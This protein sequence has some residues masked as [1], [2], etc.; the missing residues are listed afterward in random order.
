MG[1][2]YESEVRTTAHRETSTPASLH[3]N[4]RPAVKHSIL[5]LIAFANIVSITFG[6]ADTIPTETKSLQRQVAVPLGSHLPQRFD[7]SVRASDIDPR[8]KE[9]P[10][11]GFVFNDNNGKPRD[12]QHAV[13]DTRVPP[14]GQ[15]VI[16][17]M[18]HNQGLFER[19]A[20]YGLHGIQPHYANGWF[21]KLDAKDRDD[22]VSLGKI[23]LEAAT[24]QD[25]SP[26]VDIPEPDGMVQHRSNF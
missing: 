13:V 2:K 5:T 11:L 4:N 18:G 6:Q 9:H 21:G 16:W 23:R 20:S 15:L 3:S 14:R 25:Y 8:A 10:T 19:V 7:L 22:S 24:G 17:L 1:E 12:V 26:L